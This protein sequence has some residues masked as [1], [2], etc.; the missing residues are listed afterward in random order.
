VATF[1]VMCMSNYASSTPSGGQT[2]ADVDVGAATLLVGR[3][4]H[5]AARALLQLHEQAST[6]QALSQPERVVHVSLA[7]LLFFYLAALGPLLNTAAASCAR[8]SGSNA[9]SSAGSSSA[10][11]S[12]SAAGSSGSAPVAA[13]AGALQQLQQK[14]LL[15]TWPRIAAAINR[16]YA[17]QREDG[18]V[19][20]DAAENEFARAFPPA[21]AQQLL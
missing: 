8:S 13:G 5:V 7:V 14:L 15:E 21:D 2:L 3:A 11:S 6:H 1:M 17:A 10:S 4:L 9:G 18:E 20:W 12:S 19:P 16:V